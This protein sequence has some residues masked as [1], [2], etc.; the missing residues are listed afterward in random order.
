M[1]DTR[2]QTNRCKMAEASLRREIGLNASDFSMEIVY[3]RHSTLY[4]VKGP[5][6]FVWEG[7]AC[8]PY[9]ARVEAYDAYERHLREASRGAY[10]R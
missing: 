1:H 5:A 4:T 6:K 7:C 8:C 3:H 10:E 2:T 9:R